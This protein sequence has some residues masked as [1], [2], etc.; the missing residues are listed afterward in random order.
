MDMD[1]FLKAR[2]EDLIRKNDDYTFSHFLTAEEAAFAADLCKRNKAEFLFFGGYDDS[3]RKM[4]AISSLDE[5]TLKSCFPITLLCIQGPMV[6]QLSNRDVLGALMATGIRREMLGDI[7]VRDGKALFFA[8][9][10]IV[11][12]LIQNVETIGRQRVTLSVAPF[13][14]EIPPP[15]FEEMR[16]TV[17]SLRLD[18]VVGGIAHLSRDQAVRL[19]DERRVYLNHCLSTKKIKE[20]RAGDCLVLR[21]IGKWIIDCCDGVTKKGRAVISCKKYI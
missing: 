17:A 20:V 3:E 18:A 11:D 1:D 2:I 7:I 8:A 19:I 6:D 9:D 14:F 21:G 13:D 16:I 10:Q 15:Q 4:L 12:F 5:Q